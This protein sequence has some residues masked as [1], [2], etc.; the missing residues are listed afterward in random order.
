MGLDFFPDWF[1]WDNLLPA[2]IW[3]SGAKNKLARTS[4]ICTGWGTAV[5]LRWATG[6]FSEEYVTRQQWKNTSLSHCPF[7]PEG[8]CGFSRHGTYE[9]KSPAGV[10]IARFYCPKAH[11]TVS[12]LPEFMASS[13]PDTLQAIETMVEA[14]ESGT[15]QQVAEQFRPPEAGS[16]EA[17]DLGAAIRLVRRRV[18]AVHNVLQTVV[19]LF[20][21]LFAGCEPTIQSFR[22]ALKTEMVLVALCG[23]AAV[24]LHNLPPPLGFGPRPTLRRQHNS[25]FQHDMGPDPPGWTI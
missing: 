11:R 20:P 9:R 5:Q 8:G 12:L 1:R 3:C 7:H 2:W 14:R 18:K 10:K 19:G 22:A 4:D 24:H 17:P 23:I 21:D 25:C 6:L 15:E 13:F 16:R